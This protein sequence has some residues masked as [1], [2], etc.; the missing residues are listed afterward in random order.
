M[1]DAFIYKNGKLLEVRHVNVGEIINVE[2][3]PR[4]YEIVLQ[5]CPKEITNANFDSGLRPNLP[6]HRIA[7]SIAKLQ[8]RVEQLEQKIHH[9]WQTTPTDFPLESFGSTHTYWPEGSEL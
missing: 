6:V 2:G 9:N 8:R 7:R 5:D 4:E 3:D 1:K